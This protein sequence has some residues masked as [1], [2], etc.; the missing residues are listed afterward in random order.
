MIARL[1]FCFALVVGITCKSQQPTTSYFYDDA[2]YLASINDVHFRDYL[3]SY[4]DPWFTQTIKFMSTLSGSRELSTQCKSSL[5]RWL[6]GLEEKEA[7]AIK[8]LESTGKTL[9]GKLVGRNINF[10]SFDFC[11]SFVRSEREN[12]DFDGKFCVVSMQTKESEIIRNQTSFQNYRKLLSDRSK[13]LLDF[14][15]GNAHGVCLPSTCEIEELTKAA[16]KIFEP[17]GFRVLPPSRCTT[18]TEREPI[19]KLQIF[20]LWVFLKKFFQIIWDFSKPEFIPFFLVYLLRS[21][22]PCVLH[23]FSSRMTFYLPSHSSK[24]GNPFTTPSFETS[25]PR[26]RLT[27]TDG[28]QCF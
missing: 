8:L 25:S 22:S 27:C 10:G 12:I 7:W 28:R 16:N 14:S 9:N 3:Q 19:T 20:S 4:Y 11:L 15:I 6:T 13:R 23:H 18:A 2:P 1:V 17:I 26:K 24:I 21:S 5:N